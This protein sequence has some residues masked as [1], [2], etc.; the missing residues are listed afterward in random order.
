MIAFRNKEGR[1]DKSLADRRR[2]KLTKLTKF[3]VTKVTISVYT[4]EYVNVL[5]FRCRPTNPAAF[6]RC[7]NSGRF[8]LHSAVTAHCKHNS[9]G[10]NGAARQSM[11]CRVLQSDLSIYINGLC[12]RNHFHASYL[13]RSL[14]YTIKLSLTI[15]NFLLADCL[16][17][18]NLSRM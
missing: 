14:A 9:A 17:T 16:T 13:T 2:K 8:G 11:L 3:L 15:E 6:N 18:K 1:S 5:K 7:K 12:F 4:F 10:N